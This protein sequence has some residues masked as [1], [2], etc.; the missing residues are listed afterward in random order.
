M[1]ENKNR[2][3]TFLGDT[4]EDPDKDIISPMPEI[5]DAIHYEIMKRICKYPLSQKFYLVW[6]WIDYKIWCYKNK[7]LINKYPLTKKLY[8]EWMLNDYK[9]RVYKH[10]E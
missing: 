5:L 9:M 6:R 7:N 2:S 10:Q 8:L 3:F 4:I 1:I